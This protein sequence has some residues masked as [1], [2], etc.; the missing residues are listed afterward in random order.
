MLDA[1]LYPEIEPY[2][3]GYLTVSQQPRHRIHFK[4]YGNPQGEPVMML[5]GGPGSPYSSKAPRFFDPERFRIIV[6]D[7]RGCGKSEPLHSLEENTTE[8]LVHDI[9]A[10][11]RHLKIDGRMHL[12]G[13]SWGSF[14]CLVYAIRHPEQI[15]SLTLRGIFLGRPKDLHDAYQRNAERPRQEFDGGAAIFTEAWLEFVGAVPQGERQDMLDAYYRRIHGKGEFSRQ[16][17]LHAAQHWCKWENAT[18]SLHQK[19]QKALEES[20]EE[21]DKLW[22]TALLETHYF[23]HAC[24]LDDDNYIPNQAA[25][26]AHLPISIIQGRYDLVTPRKMADELVAAINRARGEKNM[27]PLEPTFTTAAHAMTDEENALLLVKATDKLPPIEREA[28]HSGKKAA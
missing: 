23:R 11:R 21:D 14:L 4:E 13:G 17:R 5:H 26:I 22:A 15:A 20:V 25:R 8:A 12:Y 19:T 27:A 28:Q 16:E 3:T 9:D 7:Q 1:I 18:T 24:F 2:R 6:H 10:L